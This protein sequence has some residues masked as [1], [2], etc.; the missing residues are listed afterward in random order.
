MEE[1]R[2]KLYEALSQSYDLGD[3][4]TF[5]TKMD[6][7]DSRKK[8]YDQVSEE[9]D[10][11]DYETFTQK[12]TGTYGA[13]PAAEEPATVAE[14]AAE[15]ATEKRRGTIRS[16]MR[17]GWKMLVAGVESFVGEAV[18]KITGE[19]VNKITGKTAQDDID[20][21]YELDEML[22][23]GKNVEEEIEG[24][25][26]ET[27]MALRKTAA[28][29]IPSEYLFPGWMLGKLKGIV[30][31]K[32]AQQQILAD[33]RDALIEAGGDVDKAREILAARS[34]DL[35]Y[36][37]KL[38]RKAGE[39][40]ANI[41][42]SE[43]AGEWIGQ[44]LVQMVPSAAALIV[45]ALTKSPAAARLIGGLGMGA[46][47]VST[48]GSTMLE[49]RQ[50]GA[51]DYRV[52][53]AGIID[54]L[55]ELVTEKLPFDNYTKHQLA[56]VK[57][58]V[59]REFMEVLSKKGNV[60][61][62]E[63]ERLLVKANEMLGGKLF[64]KRNL[65]DYMI[66]I[67]VE[68][69]S[70]FT[71]EAL[72][73]MSAIIYKDKENYPTITEAISN[74][75][76]G[77]LAGIFM[78]SVLGGASKTLEH[79]QNRARRKKQ[80]YVD[81]ALVDFGQDGSEV[82]EIVEVN[83]D[84]A[85]VLRDGVPTTVSI[86]AIGQGYR[87]TYEEF[88]NERLRYMEDDA[89]ASGNVS[90]GQIVASEERIAVARK[91]LDAAMTKAGYTSSQKAYAFAKLDAS[92][93][94]DE[95][96]NIDAEVLEAMD[97][98][99][100]AVHRSGELQSARARQEQNERNA[101]IGSI[102]QKTGAQFWKADDTVEY[103]QLTDGRTVYILSPVNAAG[104]AAGVTED[105]KKIV[106]KADMLRNGTQSS[107]LDEYVASLSSQRR[108][109]SEQSRI[110]QETQSRIAE[111]RK[112][113]QPGVEINLGTEEAPIMGTIIQ[114][115][116][117]GVTVQTENGVSQLTWSE[118]GNAMRIG[119]A[120]MTDAELASAEA[121][122]I[123]D[124]EAQWRQSRA[125]SLDGALSS[126]EDQ[127]A[128]VQQMGD[129]QPLPLKADGSVDQTTLWNTNPEG[130][131][132]WN[133][134]RRND[135]GANSLQ[136]I[137]AAIA[138]EQANF[139]GLTV[140]YNE[141][142]DFDAKDAMELQIRESLQRIERLVTLQ[143]RYSQQT[144]QTAQMPAEPV[145]TTTE[146]PAETVNETA[147]EATEEVKPRERSIESEL[148]HL[149]ELDLNDDEIAANLA[150]RKAKA[151]KDLKAQ[152]K[153]APKMGDDAEAYVAKKKEHAQK[154]QDLQAEL[155]FWTEANAAV[156]ELRAS[157]T[158]VP[159]AS[160]MAVTETD[161]EPQNAVEFAASELGKKDGEIK[162]QRDSF[163]YH[164]GYGNEE[165]RKLFGLFKSRQDGGMTLEEAGERLMEMDREYGTGF[166]DQNDPNAGLS[167]ILHA[168][169]ANA[170]MGDL[171][172]YTARQRQAEAQRNAEAALADMM[173]GFEMTFG[174]T[175][176]E[177]AHYDEVRTSEIMRDSLSDEEYNEKNN[178]FAEEELDY[179]TRTEEVHGRRDGE[180]PSDVEGGEIPAHQRGDSVLQPQPAV[181]TGR[182]GAPQQTGERRSD[183]GEVLQQNGAAQ[184]QPAQGAAVEQ[185]GRISADEAV[186]RATEMFTSESERNELDR[187]KHAALRDKVMEWGRKLGLNVKIM[188]SLDD[189]TNAE[190]REQIMMG[191]AV[192]GWYETG[193]GEVCVYMPDFMSMPMYKALSEVDKTIIH[194][195]VSHAGLRG[196]LGEARYAELCDMVWEAM[197]DLAKRRFITYPGVN[198]DTRAAADEFIAKFSENVDYNMT[199]WDKIV[200]FVKDLFDRDGL[201]TKI[202]NETLSQLLRDS[203]A[204]YTMTASAKTAVVGKSGNKTLFSI[205]TYE[206]GG[207]AYLDQWLKRDENTSEEDRQYILGTMDFMHQVANEMKDRYPAF[208]SWSYAEV[209]TD[210]DGNPIMSVIKNNGDYAMNL[211]FS[212]GCKKRR[213]LN[214]LLNKMIKDGMFE[215]RNFS[216]KEIA[217]I[218]QIIQ[219][220]GFEVAC[221]LCF[222]D[223]KRY[224]VA[225]VAFQFTSMYN[226]LV[227]SLV[228]K[229]SG[230]QIAWYNYMGNPSQTAMDEVK[231]PATLISNLPDEALDWTKIDKILKK[232]EGKTSLNVQEKIAKLLKSDAK[233]RKNASITDFISDK[234][235]ELVTKHNP[236]LLKL[237]NAKKG[238][239]GPKASLGDVQ[240]LN[241]ILKSGS[242]AAERAY[243]VG[244]VRLQSFS[245]YMPHM[246]FDYMQMMAELAGKKLP[247]H[248]YTKEENFARIFGMTG[249]KINLS[250]V[251]RVVDGGIAPG[252]DADGNYAWAEEYTDE[253]GNVIA[254]QTFPP[255]VAF[256]MQKDPRYSGNVGAI[257]VGI[258][259]EQITRMLDDENIHYIIPYHK[260]S[261]NPDVAKM[262]K[263]DQFVDYTNTQ[264][265]KLDPSHPDTPKGKLTAAQKKAE[266]AKRK[267]DFYGSLAQTNDPKQTAA[268]YL[269][270]CAAVGLIP[271]FPQFAGHE[272]YYKLLVDFNTYD[273]VTGKYAPQGPVTMTFPENVSELIESG[274]A[275]DQ[276]LDD[277]LASEVNK[278]AEE[279][280][281]E[282]TR[283][284]FRTRTDEQRTALFDAAK[285][286]YGVTN[287]FKVAGYML[288]DGSLLDFSEANDGGNPNMRSL[289]HRAIAGV[290]EDRDYDTMT[291]Y[292]TDFLNEGAIRMMP[293]SDAINLSVAPSAEQRERLLDYFYK[294][295]GYIILEI[296]DQNGR[297]TVYMEY[298]K[299]TSPYRIMR[300]IDGYFNE[301]TV[302]SQTRF[303]ISNE[304]QA[305]FVSNAAKAVEGIKM[306]KATPE[307]WL[308]MIE[309]NG[310]LKAGEDKWM[311]LSD[312]LKASDKK[313]LT[314][315]EVMQFV[316]E[317][318]IHIEE[319]HYAANA[320]RDAEDTYVKI[321]QILQDKFDDYMQEY[322]ESHD[323][324]DDYGDEA[325]DFAMDKLHEEFNDGFP[326]TIER[327]QS[328]VYLTFPYEEVEDLEEWAAK[329]GIDFKVQNPIN[330]TRLNYTTEGLDNK[331]EIALTVPTIES[332]NADDA[333]H[334]GDAGDGRAVAWIRFGETTDESG[335][336][337][338]VI[339]EIQS[340]RHQKG[341]E[342]GYAPKVKVS[343]TELRQKVQ[344]F[345]Q[346]MIDKYHPK[347]LGIVPFSSAMRDIWTK[348]ERDVYTEMITALGNAASG[349]P[350]APFEKNWHELAMKRMLRYAAEN[351]FDVVAWTKGEQQGERYNLTEVISS[352]EYS[353][354]RD[355][356]TYY[357]YPKDKAGL[358]PSSI[359]TEFK[360]EKQ[361]AE[362]YG[363][364]IAVKIV[365]DLASIKE[366]TEHLTTQINETIEQ[367]KEAEKEDKKSEKVSELTEKYLSLANTRDKLWMKEFKIEGEELKVGG[368]GMKGF[369]DRMLPAFMDK[370]GKKWGVKTTDIELPN[371]EN[372]L[373]MH[374]VPV[375][376]E[377]KTSVME[378]Q[379][380]FRVRETDESPAH[381]LKETVAE[382]EG[383][384][385]VV[386]SSMVTIPT[387]RA[388][389]EALGLD[390]SHIDESLYDELLED[391]KDYAA[392]YYNITDEDKGYSFRKVVIFA[393]D[394]YATSYHTDAAL[395]HENIHSFVNDDTALLQLG[396]WLLN[397]ET[398]KKSIIK[399][400]EYVKAGYKEADHAEEM[401]TH[402]VSASMAAG[403]SQR[404][405]DYIPDEYK[406]LLKSIYERFGF[407]PEDEDGERSR[408]YSDERN[409]AAGRTF[410]RGEA[411]RV[412][413]TEP[414]TRF[415]VVGGLNPDQI[416][417]ATDNTGAFSAENSDIRY[418]VVTDPAKIEELENG[419]K[420]KVYRAMQLI[421]GKLYP[422]MSAKVD[423]EL[424]EPIELGQWEEAEERPDLAD[425]K[426]YFKLDKGNKKSLKARYNPY[427]HTS[428]TPLNDQFS[429]AQDRPN[430]VTVEVEIPVSELT[431]GYKAEKAK[432][433]VGEK[434]W[435][436]GVIQGKLS[437]TRKVIL[438]RWDK[439]IRI[440]PDSEV[441]DVIVKMFEGKD[442]TM[443]SN[444]VTPSLRAELEKRGVPFM[445]TDNTGKPKAKEEVFA[446]DYFQLIDDLFS[447][448]KNLAEKYQM[449]YFDIAETPDFY[450]AIGIN[451]DKFTVKYG[452]ISVHFGKDEDHRMTKEAWK[453]LPSALANPIFIT[454]Y[455]NK[456]NKF[457]IYT[458]IKLGDRFVIAGVDV[459][460]SNQGKNKPMI[461]INSIRT[462][463][464][465]K[466][467]GDDEKLICYNAEITPEQEALLNGRNFRQYPTIQELSESKDSDNI[468]T[469][470]EYEE[471]ISFRTTGTP[472]DEVVAKGITLSPAETARLAGN[473]F[474]ALSA[475]ERRSITDS[476]KGDFLGMRKAI[477]QIPARL[478][479][480]ENW[481]ENDYRL[482]SVVA[483]ELQKI[484]GVELTRPLSPS[485]ALWMLYNAMN[486]DNV[487]DLV[488]QAQRVLVRR[489]LGFD[490][491]TQ[492]KLADS[493]NDTRFRILRNAVDNAEASLYNQGAVNVWAR[494]KESFVDM[495]TSVEKLV[496]SIEKNS[497]KEIK[498]FE[499]IL[500]ALNQQSS[501]GLAAVESYMSKFLNPMLDA[502]GDIMRKTGKSYNDVVRYVILKHGIERNEAFAK[503]DAR[504]FYKSEFDRAA[505]AINADRSLDDSQK[506]AKLDAAE[507]EYNRHVREIEAGTD[508]K[509]LELRERDYSGITSMFYDQLDVNRGDYRTEEEYQAALMRAKQDRYQTL[510]DV[511]DAAEREVDDFE[512]AVNTEDL[513][514]K[515][516]GAT[517]EILRQ[518]YQSN[519]ISKDQYEALR[520]MF[521]FY[522]PLRGFKDNTA[523]DM[524]TYYRK[525]NST[526]YTKP[527]LGA[528]GRS[529]E[530]ESPFGWIAAMANSAIA[531]NVKNEAKLALYYFVSN[532]PD[533][534]IAVITKTW[535]VDSGE[536]DAEGKKIF[537]PAYPPFA[538]DLSSEE[539]KAAYEAWQANMKDLQSK[540]MAYE[541]GQ[542]LN[543]GNSVV[544]ISEANRPE[545]VV[546]IKVGGKDYSIIINGN[547]R[548]AQAINGD[549]NLESTA[550]DYSKLFGPV[551]R[552]MSSVNTSY[553]PEFWITN[554]QRDMLFTFMNVSSSKSPEYRRLF[555]KNYGKAFKVFRLVAKNENGTIGDSYMENL[556]K[557][558]VEHGGVTGYTQLKDNEVWEQE[559]DKY[560]KS[561][562]P[563]KGNALR[564]IKTALHAMHRFGESM[565]QVSR[566]AAFLT[567]R[568]MGMDIREAIN[569][570][571]EITVNFNRKGSGK[572]ISLAELDHLTD[573]NGKPLNW[574][575][576]WTAFGLS[577]IAPLGRRCI[578]FFNAAIQGL[579]S[580]YKL[581]K[582]NPSKIAAWAAGYF[583]LGVLQ[584][585]LHAM[586]DDDDDYLDMPQYARRT[587]LMLGGNG[588]YFKWALP[589][590]ARMFYAIGD[591]AV[592]AIMGRNPHQNVVG[593]ALKLVSDVAP[594]NPSE[595]WKALVPS[596]GVPLVEIVTNEDY[597]GD[598]I[599]SDYKW[600][601][602]E[603][604]KRTAKW[605]GAKKGT[606][607]IYV[608]LSQ[609]LN[610]I[611]GG[612]EFDAG[613]INL[614]PEKYEHIVQSAFGGT[615]RTA[616]KFI[617]TIIA[618]LDPDEEW[619]VRQTPFINRILTLNDE[620]YRNVHVNDVY[621]WYEAEA[622]HVA[623]LEKKYT[624]VKDAEA[625][626]RLRQS[627]E[628]QWMKIYERYKK[629][630]KELKERIKVS[631][632]SSER[633]EL[634]QRLDELK[635]RMIQEI[636]QL[637]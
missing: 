3:F 518:Q 111:I 42:P 79:T 399:T 407:N 252:L 94:P 418:R 309:K 365:G 232:A 156:E 299:G 427:F 127:D 175:M 554:M 424:R 92:E 166:F 268:D 9:Y 216:E 10:L 17:K 150:A 458:S 295:N 29:L 415:R 76:Q 550:G 244:G 326:Y 376:E 548:A 103:G 396:E 30:Q 533:N 347:D 55:I 553:N 371:L 523:E 348:E 289:D 626:S 382:F 436:A 292:I 97:Y 7:E 43:G 474:A 459:I 20:A 196:L 581:A 564:K 460:R 48:A 450:K 124:V 355:G 515:I 95:I 576:K 174:M 102:Q 385:N 351:G 257:A 620:R 619:T 473:I 117:D 480:K 373:T 466:R 397:G 363:K 256:E 457:R 525:P 266:L 221:A 269:A 574:L 455:G 265:E 52:W 500:L 72:Q 339:D 213:P 147:P 430:L 607:R 243:K 579:N 419:E 109:A 475:E 393:K 598:A 293:E 510:E 536:V 367:L 168:L 4:D 325:R 573:R 278:V 599:Y 324:E 107:T 273:F 100:D 483:E 264:T 180:I 542:R 379:T 280:Y 186:R 40:M 497:G 538:E 461:E 63:I 482:A 605:S 247:A 492:E 37:D 539:G 546:N 310:G 595:G 610:Q 302:P 208:S 369:Y 425:N 238:T 120:P 350:A 485:E 329:V 215:G 181:H 531:S 571:K 332:W 21:L 543:L 185:T 282:M 45:G 544:N 451:G 219:K 360:D 368:E 203:Y 155:D 570:A 410:T 50:E 69:S 435:K 198:G 161:L 567:A 453:E 167:A 617:N 315:D 635:K 154:M 114:I 380:M 2:K 126:A 235:F 153:K 366:E 472:T 631:T 568:E 411:V 255:A 361:I 170:T 116:P 311:G 305:I 580:M 601:S 421:D 78:G 19:A 514:K 106:V 36:G 287:N 547:P 194:E 230:Y 46:M 133:D 218:N 468:D 53:K 333:T 444:V 206:E 377:M 200:K 340:K 511:E 383:K 141:E 179:D 312:W 118:A 242:F 530:A 275:E 47:S 341:R 151:L 627:E 26:T 401:L 131:A 229:N 62:S 555:R 496:K 57:K 463:F 11:G 402:Y 593:E 39:D 301:G 563:E 172:S 349:V 364:E 440:V 337:V 387:K 189:V 1:S 513:W 80:G 345:K 488:S 471:N 489:N 391:W 354:S 237:Y 588:V 521:Q 330:D 67:L 374:S 395:F 130:W 184:V 549:L 560:M 529:T 6:S 314:K 13:A 572:M 507:K 201:P 241:D 552:W 394:V 378:G 358:Q 590:E 226:D 190:A 577:S 423:G 541:S 534:G 509:Y 422:P 405:M 220:H 517:K 14:Q 211:D 137:T 636:S 263:I 487:Y 594:V 158:Q 362:V 434:E 622:L 18:N 284:V 290:I 589:Q 138:R 288:P 146:A 89:I 625:L 381:F 70:E 306:E 71:A 575:A 210:Q 545:H 274:L 101:I 506:Q 615:I 22:R 85:V 68:G 370:Y 524:Y 409:R 403:Q 136:Y 225:N 319:V 123:L 304:H 322:Y 286:Q 65:K 207:R 603:E 140:R 35:S 119:T 504:E 15:E 441:A 44:N 535:F 113:A 16:G 413:T 512:N 49:A 448:K 129:A 12:M 24:A 145:V 234:G 142:A 467:I 609:F 178:I 66:D 64:S 505:E 479:A 388:F 60:A 584:A 81:V 628:Y 313:T 551:L 214:A 464:A 442:I 245:D 8:L 259:D 323:V 249:M 591:L 91:D 486:P 98:Y 157:E 132:D 456:E 197:P 359:P 270:H 204:R 187:N 149:Y 582:N 618:L 193:T 296:D 77:F 51:N 327:S 611:S 254:T 586:M 420:I 41:E 537:K 321:Q 540:G 159:T 90:D 279:V 476:L 134:S 165:M 478:A 477:M 122:D 616:D 569:E 143:Q 452:T 502:V 233:Y 23:G 493:K 596:A 56:K 384:Y 96:A 495:Y 527:I 446:K 177:A 433:S 199:L 454:Q 105:G 300:D 462:V 277:R 469:S 416:K 283:T 183:D 438:S 624:A 431:S 499:N 171:R 353:L 110:A 87:Y 104:E 408:R 191:K 169:G 318:M 432:D 212:L 5:N 532:R 342:K 372:G 54:G 61:R 108:S 414:G 336:K 390:M 164:T 163:K 557:E 281:S 258:S 621:D 176:E 490:S 519:M 307:Q 437:G 565:E 491:Q 115:N 291:E 331:R 34:K 592:E 439:P 223:A 188:E 33:I 271:K 240:Y 88:E 613:K 93:F 587:S 606:G 526:G 317:H 447:G 443:P 27:G 195:V 294:K 516:N 404:T 276:Q 84:T 320:E 285:A 470:N 343:L 612:D 428:Y 503:R 597:K 356:S 501:K 630:V 556:Y 498:P 481:D 99:I 222:V 261:L 328:D 398:E 600:L 217:R 152:E 31:D 224:R 308:K 74:G 344:D 236:E 298:D 128:A 248:A 629:P 426:G 559:I 602:K 412:N 192:S 566:F 316:N 239:G 429:E 484:M 262:T 614:Q 522:V 231:D 389:A 449:R 334:F 144:E 634:V 272:N 86:D 338:L 583:A 38:R 357:V 148:A 465:A 561:N 352:I 75:W 58:Q 375:T 297:S 633:K 260:S 608:W 135:G 406:P 182:E 346:E 400:R 82:V 528:E 139:A 585:V 250:L 494:L 386:P 83:G 227:R 32:I 417:S 303:R 246:F 253:N 228:P 623:T 637:P 335:N 25:W 578:M 162:L 392:M 562:D 73:T 251:P 445:E 632:G 508:A 160:D 202:T 558:F 173:Y 520:D 125:E 112:A 205:R 28:E 267:F 59:S 604:K 121:A 209:E